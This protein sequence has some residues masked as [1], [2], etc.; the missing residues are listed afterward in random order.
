MP[1]CR[2]LLLA[3]A[4]APDWRSMSLVPSSGG[5]AAAD[6]LR[7]AATEC[8]TGHRPPAG[9]STPVPPVPFRRQYP[10]RS[11]PTAIVVSPLRPDGKPLPPPF[12]FW[13]PSF[14]IGPANVPLLRPVPVQ[15][16]PPQSG[17]SF[18]PTR[19]VPAPATTQSGP[20]FPNL[21]PPDGHRPDTHRLSTTGHEPPV[22]SPHTTSA[23]CR[24]PAALLPFP[25]GTP[26][27]ALS[28]CPASAAAVGHPPARSSDSAAPPAKPFLSPSG[29]SM[30]PATPS[31][32]PIGHPPP[33]S[34]SEVFPV[35]RPP[36]ACGKP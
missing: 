27:P 30:P 18:P 23:A 25:C 15:P 1:P 6:L 11:Q 10:S 4:T 24:T 9:P 17:G 33:A 3:G 14:P 28:G 13:L 20:H 22:P 31:S 12:P 19:H 8:P 26:R 36:A 35:A 29:P 21:R 2:L 16:R 32:H 7:P 5:S 34:P